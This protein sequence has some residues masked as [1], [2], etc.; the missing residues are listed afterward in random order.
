MIC[1]KCNNEIPEESAFCPKCG[2]SI[3]GAKPL[4]DDDT[5]VSKKKL[6]VKAIVGVV[7]AIVVIVA[8]VSTVVY[9]SQPST[10]YAKA[11]KAFNNQDFEKAVKYYTAAGV[12]EDAPNKLIEAN[13]AYSY[14]QGKKAFESAQYD[15][16]IELLEASNSYED[17]DEL[18]IQ[19]NYNKGLIE[20]DAGNYVAAAECFKF[21]MNY[22]NAND[23]IIEMGQTLVNNSDYENAVSI[24][25]Y[26]KNGDKDVYAQ[27]AKGQIAYSGKRYS[28]A[29]ACFEAAGDV[30]DAK[31]L[32]IA[33]TYNDANEKLNFK[34][35]AA[36]AALFSKTNGYEDSD[37]LLNACNL[38]EAKQQMNDGNLNQALTDLKKLPSGYSY[39]GVNSSDLLSKLEENS[40][41]L[42][43]CGRWSSTYGL[44]S[45]NC[46]AKRG[47]Y[48]GGTWSSTFDNGDSTINIKCVLNTD[49]SVTVSGNTSFLI[50]TNWSTIQIG[51]KYDR[52]HSVS[53]NQKFTQADLGKSIDIG[54]DTSIVINAD[55]IKIKYDKVDKTDNTSFNYYYKTDVTYGKKT[56]SN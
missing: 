10:K 3:G 14:V 2:Y 4:V 39:N 6:T 23:L 54:N 42:D 52:N 50:F 51:L 20:K 45:S 19:C 43:I 9:N 7:V 22:E 30:L 44:A 55:E 53:F 33:A 28:E 18:L 25:G 12:Y 24:F 40:I 32:Y 38:M 8:I 37:N 35:Y 49:G 5:N 21:A 16:A 26:A 27:Y 46:K 1:P 15:E 36:A 17:A 29:A 56:S 31:D 48:D 47:W 34:N 41:W 13:Y 11:E